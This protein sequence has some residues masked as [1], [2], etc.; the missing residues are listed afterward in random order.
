MFSDHLRLHLIGIYIEMLRQVNT[1]AQAA[2]EGA[3]AQ[4]AVVPC[5]GA[6]NIG[7]RIRRIDY[8]QYNRARRRA[9]N[10]RNDVTVNFSVRI[11]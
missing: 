5:A 2:E 3:R 6:R 10:A 7:E 8:H 1:E 11:E 4:H 9:R